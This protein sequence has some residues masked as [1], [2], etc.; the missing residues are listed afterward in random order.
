MC[1]AALELSETQDYDQIRCPQCGMSVA[2]GKERLGQHRTQRKAEVRLQE[3]EDEVHFAE[4]QIDAQSITRTELLE[5]SKS[6]LRVLKGIRAFRVGVIF[7]ILCTF[8]IGIAAVIHAY[9][10]HPDVV[11]LAKY[12]SAGLIIPTVFFALLGWYHWSKVA[13]SDLHV[14]RNL[15][16]PLLAISK[17]GFWILFF[18]PVAAGFFAAETLMDGEGVWGTVAIGF[19]IP[20]FAL[21]ALLTLSIYQI[22][23]Y[24][25]SW[26]TERVSMAMMIIAILV[27]LLLTF[28]AILP[29]VGFLIS[30]IVGLYWNRQLSRIGRESLILLTEL[31]KVS[32]G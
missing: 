26:R 27:T 12:I 1:G 3:D 2:L 18:I 10:V 5:L 16:L 11:K 13:P 29:I 20:G 7:M 14:R 24:L 21:P 32:Q 22:K 4:I 9:H 17:F 6:T 30:V 31:S 28:V 19:F 25:A 8:L 23:R 15:L